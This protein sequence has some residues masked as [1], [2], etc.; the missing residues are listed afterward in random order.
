MKFQ[1]LLVLSFCFVMPAFAQDSTT[2]TQKKCNCCTEQHRQFDFWL[3]DWEAYSKD[4]KKL[5]GKNNLISMEDGCVMQENWTSGS[6]PYTGTSYN[7]YNQ[8]TKKW[9]QLWLDNQGGYL[10]LEGE[11]IDGNMVLSSKELINA[12]GEKYFNRI[13]WIPLKDGRVR[14]HW[15]VTKDNG[16][17]WSTSFDGYY[18]KIKK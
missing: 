13:T 5:L 3:G 18:Q 17:T 9:E 8:L 16:K 1:L 12:K 10:K 15:E 2:V 6:S 7:F 4:G 14:Q 11:L